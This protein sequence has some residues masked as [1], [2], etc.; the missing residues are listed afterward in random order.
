MLCYIA[1]F[2]SLQ[3][4]QVFRQDELNAHPANTR[5]IEQVFDKPRGEIITA[6]GV[7]LAQ[8]VP[9]DPGD[10]FDLQR[11]YPTGDLF[12]DVTGYFTLANG[13]SQVEKVYNDV[14]SGTAPAQVVNNIGN[15]LGGHGDNS[16]TVELTLRADFQRLAKQLL[17]ER[18][19]SIVMLD[20]RTGAVLA[21]YSWPTYD[22]NLIADHNTKAAANTLRRLD[23]DTR[24]PLLANAYQ[25][26]YMPGSAFKLVTTS[27]ALTDG[28][29]TPDTQFAVENQYTPPQTNDPVENYGGKSCG[30]DLREVFRRSCNTPFARIAVELGG[31][32]FTA[33]ADAF[34]VNDPPPFD[35]PRPAASFVN[36]LGEKFDQNLPILA[37]RGFGSENVQITPLQMAMIAA[38]IANGGEMMQ[39]YVVARTVDHDGRTLSATTPHV[40]KIPMSKDIADTM[41]QLMIGVV[42]GPNGTV[43]GRFT[44]PGGV[45]AAAK[46]G[47]AQL[48]RK[49]EK[50][51]SHAWITAFAPAEA[52]QF[53]VSVF[54][55]G[56]NDE[57]SSGTGGRLAGPIAN[58]MLTYALLHP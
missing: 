19:G 24:N 47:T 21:M 9:T 29:V 25:E 2:A 16:G 35:L 49:G 52:P 10:R 44:L 38:C 13:A 50:Q 51:R 27:T 8:S 43:Q 12:A 55:K 15:I 14:L 34:G 32:R 17:G 36:S 22:P 3:L 53:V 31:D 37:Q 33:G 48:N 39:P 28:V 18:E 5:K 58:Q 54:L 41:T 46:T 6:D 1:L 56:V 4:P 30:G 20:P 7:V 26:R 45:Q 57:I 23:S 40:W 42:N 11:T